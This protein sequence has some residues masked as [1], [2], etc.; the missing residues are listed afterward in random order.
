MTKGWKNE[1][2]RHGFSAKGIRT[3]RKSVKKPKW[4]D[5]T[6]VHRM[7]FPPIDMVI[8]ELVCVD[9]GYPTIKLKYSL[10]M[11]GE[12]REQGIE[13]SGEEPYCLVHGLNEGQE[14]E[15]QDMEKVERVYEMAR[16]HQDC[17]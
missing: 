11:V 12:Y 1:G 8:H 6:V 10:G 3:G 17:S 7:K 2:E 14:V 16:R 5:E 4:V 15:E 13:V 9:C